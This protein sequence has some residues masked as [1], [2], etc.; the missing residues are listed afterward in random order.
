MTRTDVL[1]DQPQHAQLRGVANEA[2]E[3]NYAPPIYFLR[4]SG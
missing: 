4:K 1:K 2:E 3:R